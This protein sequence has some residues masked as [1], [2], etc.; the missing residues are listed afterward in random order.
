MVSKNLQPTTNRTQ[1]DVFITQMTGIIEIDWSEPFLINGV[2]CYLVKSGEEWLVAS[3]E[4][5]KF[6]F[7][8]K[9]EIDA[10]EQVERGITFWQNKR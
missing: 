3:V 4:K 1:L 8:G 10:R 5:P 9:S 6:C 7:S 2:H